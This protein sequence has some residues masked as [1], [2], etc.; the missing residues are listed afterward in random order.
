MKWFPLPLLLGC[1]TTSTLPSCKVGPDYQTPDIAPVT[2]ARWKWQTAEPKDIAPR[3]EWWEVF[4]DRDLN[5]LQARALA[6]NQ[7]LRAAMARVDQARAAAGLS[8]AAFAPDISIQAAAQRERTSGNPPSPVPIAIPSSQINTYSVPLQLS[9]EIDLWGRVRR[10]LESANAQVDASGA[11]YQSVLLGLQ[12]DLASHYFLVRGLDSQTTAL[13][14]TLDS[15]EKTLGLIRQR[16]A[17][18]T[19]PEADLARSESEVATI[20]ADLADVKRQREETVSLMAVLCG[21]PAS[22]FSLAERALSG[23]LPRIPAGI[24]ASVL[25]RRP[26]VAAAERAVAARNAEIGVETAAYFPTVTLTGQGG[27]LS[28][29][30]SSLFSADSRIWAI[31][32]GVSIPITGMFL[33]KAKVQRA[34]AFHEEAIAT[35]RQ[36]VLG[37]VK[38]VET[39]LIQIR[40]R[41]EQAAAQ[42]DALAAAQK[43]VSLTRQ[44]YDGGNISYLELLD[45]ERTSLLRERQS[46]QVRAQSHLA[47]VALIRALGGA[48]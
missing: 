9:Y 25:E 38:D 2:P 22:D 39:A 44:L 4:Q 40:F 8:V 29:D 28:K 6:G 16:F 48:W 34:R 43:A 21:A 30:T 41:R 36:A 1:L 10:S 24:P 11:D 15:Q 14:R 35:Y 32:P 42:A 33:T 13:R 45:A 46:A 5:Q 3:G 20:R 47:T 26:D 27:V 31:G 37:A 23:S 17:A 18:G 12:A 19:I 7:N